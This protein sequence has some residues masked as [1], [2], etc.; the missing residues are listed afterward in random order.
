MSF[1]H[2]SR[3][4]RSATIYA[5]NIWSMAAL[6][7]LIGHY[8]SSGSVG[9]RAALIAVSGSVIGV[10]GSVILFGAAARQIGLPAPRR[11]PLVLVAALVVG[12]GVAIADAA[13]GAWLIVPAGTHRPNVWLWAIGSYPLMASLCVA[14]ATLFDVLVQQDRL[15]AQ[16]RQT[17][18]ARLNESE[19]RAAAETARLQALRWQLNPHFLFNTLN[20]I[21]VN[22]MA[23]RGAVAE[24]MLD[25]LAEFLRASLDAD[26]NRLSTVEVEFELLESYLDIEAVRFGDRLEVE[27]ICPPSLRTALLPGFLLQPLVENAIKFG[28][29][30]SARPVRLRVEALAGD[31]D[32]RLIVSDTG[33]GSA[34][35]APSAG[36]GL[37]NVRQRLALHYGERGR[38]DAQA[39]AGGFRVEL[40]LPCE[41]AR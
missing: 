14:C 35:A 31:G 24:R 41:W 29:A 5:V 8:A 7:L 15:T 36:V 16:E 3:A 23:G 40:Q 19:A 28:V 34:A 9:P 21:S 11:L 2:A 30:P 17:A 6:F 22:V 13:V 12:A 27:L 18:E 20:A 26:P 37:A 32:L 4:A 33:D 25:K 38:L 39:T 10:L 1:L